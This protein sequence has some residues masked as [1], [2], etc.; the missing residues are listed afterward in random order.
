MI[1]EFRVSNY[2]FM[3]DLEPETFMSDHNLLWYA[4]HHQVPEPEV[5]AVMLR[6]LKA[7]DCAVDAGANVGFFTVLMS[8]IVGDRGRVLAVEPDP[9]NLVKLRKNLDINSCANVE[10]AE[11][12]IGRQVGLAALYRHLD[13]GQLS[14]FSDAS[15][16]TDFPTV[17]TIPLD[18]LLLR[19]PNRPM[20]IKLDIEGSETAAVE[21]LSFKCPCIISELNSTALQRA[22][23]S[24]RDLMMIMKHRGYCRYVLHA[25][26][27]LPS[28][29]TE[30]QVIIPTRENAN[31]LFATP[32]YVA[33]ALWHEVM[34]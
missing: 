8:K 27:S 18:Q 14:L 12:A 26:G 28:L 5:I 16:P 20:L 17:E 10:I 6:G 9:H 21:S 30:D 33:K 19:L 7:G 29:V 23:S 3:F 24:A 4:Q 22:G 31:V 34:L 11:Y 1:Q 32:G 25:D 13:N 2:R 15:S